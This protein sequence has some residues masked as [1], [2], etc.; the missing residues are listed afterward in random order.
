MS[1]IAEAAAAA[2]ADK[3]ADE[4]TARQAARSA[5]IAEAREAVAALALPAADLT[6]VRGSDPIILTDGETQLA[7]ADDGVHLVTLEDGRYRDVAGPFEN[8]AALGE[9]LAGES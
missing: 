8:L 9:V 7:L 5:R 3:H 4:E 6:V 2:L 1:I